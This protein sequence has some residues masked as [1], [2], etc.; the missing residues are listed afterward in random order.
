MIETVADGLRHWRPRWIVLDPVMVAKSGDKLLAD[1][2]IDALTRHLLPLASLITPNLPE[3]GVLLG[4]PPARTREEMGR[5]RRPPAGAGPAASS[6]RAAI[7][8]RR[9]APTS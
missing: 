6:S 5:R 9:T 2:A 7:S 1:D 8:R 4:E 3:A